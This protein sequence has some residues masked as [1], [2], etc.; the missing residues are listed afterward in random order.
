LTRAIIRSN[1]GRDVFAPDS[2]A[3][4]EDF[5]DLQLVGL[6]LRAAAC[7]LLPRGLERLVLAVVVILVPVA[8]ADV[9]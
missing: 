7:L 8:V 4:L 6:E 3:I 9:D 2:S 1:A 5:A